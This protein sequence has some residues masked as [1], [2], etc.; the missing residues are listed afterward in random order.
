[1]PLNWY[2][3]GRKELDKLC[4]QNVGG[5]KYIKARENV[6]SDDVYAPATLRKKALWRGFDRGVA[7]CQKDRHSKDGPVFTVFSNLPAELR[8]I[9]WELAIPGRRYITIYVPPVWNDFA[10]C[11]TWFHP[12]DVTYFHPVAIDRAPPQ[13]FVCKEAQE[14]VNKHY[15]PLRGNDGFGT[16]FFNPEVDTLCFGMYFTSLTIFTTPFFTI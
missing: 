4:R 3:S 2:A 8:T 13:F 10:E 7:Y 15:V 9:I 12:G 11:D 1:M 5:K 14:A 6:F 16:V